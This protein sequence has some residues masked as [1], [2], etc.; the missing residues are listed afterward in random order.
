MP[1]RVRPEQHTT[2]TTVPSRMPLRRPSIVSSGDSSMFS[3]KRSIS[4]SSA[5][6]AASMMASRAAATSSATEAGIG[7][8]FRV[9]PSPVKA[10]FSSTHTTPMNWPFSMMGTS[11]GA[12]WLPYLSVMV[13]SAF[14]KLAFSR[15]IWLMTIMRAVCALS[16]AAHAFSAPTLSPETAPTVM[17]APSHTAR[18]PTSSPAK[19]K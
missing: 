12:T 17:M 2:G 3:K 16:Q 6:A 18:G 4:S 13:A 8:S 10:L 5:P 1:T 7:I 9:L 15:S 14:L 19:S 11:M